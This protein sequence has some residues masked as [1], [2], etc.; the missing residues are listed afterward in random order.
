MEPPNPATAAATNEKK[1][2]KRNI[3]NSS[4][5]PKGMVED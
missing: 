3:S 4:N 5:P 2:P 1:K